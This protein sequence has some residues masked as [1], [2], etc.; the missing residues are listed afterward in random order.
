MDISCGE[1][2]AALITKDNQLFTWGY[3]HDGQLGHQ[4]KNQLTTPVKVENVG[5]VVKVVCGGGHT[6]F[7]T[8]EGEL[9]L[10]GRGRD[11]GYSPTN[12]EAY[13]LKS[14]DDARSRRDDRFDYSEP[15]AAMKEYPI[16]QNGKSPRLELPSGPARNIAYR[17]PLDLGDPGATASL[18][19]ENRGISL[20][21]DIRAF[22]PMDLISILI[23]EDTEAR[24]QAD[25]K[26]SKNSSF[27]AAITSLLGLDS[28]IEDSNNSTTSPLSLDNAI[29]TETSSEFNGK[30]ETNRRGRLR[31]TVSAMVAEVLPSGI[32]RIEGEKIISTNGEEEVM[33]ISGLV[34]PEDV[35]TMNEIDSRKIANMRIDYSGRGTVGR[36][37]SPGWA[38]ALLDAIWPF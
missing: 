33:T 13:A 21:R 38:I 7:I 8:V 15:R 37:Q 28:K 6:A 20:M 12:M 17:S 23:I 2:H 22:A 3:G 24:S 14:R 26:L 18:W 25:T 1:E 34:R 36:Q 4:S 32:L 16:D 11:G 19:R 30:G 31:G 29:G 10:F 9:F 35:N 5:K 27:E